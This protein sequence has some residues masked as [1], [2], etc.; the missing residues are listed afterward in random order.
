MVALLQSPP[1][2]EPVKALGVWQHAIEG[3]FR[4]IPVKQLALAWWCYRAKHITKR[5]YRIWWAAQ[6]MLER[7]RYSKKDPD[8]VGSR[9]GRFQNEQPVRKPLYTID[10]IKALIGSRDSSTADAALSADVKRLGYLGLVKISAH[11]IHF[12][13]CVMDLDIE[14]QQPFWD[15]YEGLPNRRRTVPVPRRT[16]RAL[17]GGFQA[18][19]MGV[20]VGLMV[21]CLF[22]HRKG[23]GGAYRVDGRTKAAWFVDSFLIGNERSVTQARTRLMEL[24]WLAELESPQWMLNRFGKHEQINP[25]ALGPEAKKAEEAAQDKAPE[26]SAPCSDTF[27]GQGSFSGPNKQNPATSSAPCLNKSS[28]SS[29]NLKTRKPAPQRSGS[30]E[31]SR[32]GK[33]GKFRGRVKEVRSKPPTLRNVT[34]E[35][36]ADNDRLIELHRQAIEKGIPVAG[37]AGRLDFFALAERAR[38]GGHNPPKLFAWLLK[39][40][41]FDRIATA[42]EEAAA[43]RIRQL[44][45]PENFAEDQR[46]EQG[47][48]YDDHIKPRTCGGGM[49]LTDD[50]KFVLACIKTGRQHKVDPFRIAR[51]KGW[52]KEKWDTIRASYEQKDRQR[53]TKPKTDC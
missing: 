44:H 8:A 20:M 10:E 27:R 52:D 22:W 49:A 9:G 4:P 12:A 32:E 41:H 38:A 15:F 16:I 48:D 39:H 24:G 21:R 40:R 35:D 42:D 26:A 43:A 2:P 23:Q 5:Q 30:T 33:I 37:E 14:E 19:V 3:R 11:S 46:R 17:A 45:Y 47:G 13:S 51:T 7:R 6:E 1:K 28:S 34:N 29:R 50:E 36:L 25:D 53:W 31:G 18:S